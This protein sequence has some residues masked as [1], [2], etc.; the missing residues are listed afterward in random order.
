MSLISDLLSK[1]KQQEPKRDIP[2]LLKDAVLQSTTGRKARSKFTIPLVV[3]L[4]VAAGGVGALFFIDF[5]DKPAPDSRSVM[6]TMPAAR[7]HPPV[8]STSI[9]QNRP[10]G[11]L[12]VPQSVEKQTAQIA[13]KVESREIK[14]TSPVHK[15]SS[16][17]RYVK[18]I[19]PESVNDWKEVKRDKASGAGSDEHAEETE[20]IS[21]QDKDLYLYAARTYERQKDYQKALSS[22]RKVLAVD[23]RNYVVVNNISSTLIQLGSYNEAIRYAEKALQLRKDYIYS[24]INMG[25]AYSQ[26]SKYKEG[27]G[28]L[29]KA[30]SMEPSNRYVLLNL[31]LLHEKS[32]SFDK[33]RESFI[34][35]SEKGDAQGYMGLARISEKQGRT[36]EAINFYREVMSAESRDSHTWNIANDRLWQL[37]R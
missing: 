5:F 22:Y 36:A 19:T 32:G 33:A 3:A 1:V 24:L 8:A 10:V 11:A 9:Q 15:K 20:K 23:P 35:L 6:K 17:K 37:T 13:I 25:I 7:A 27:E 30:F 14:V 18:K 2:P 12:S 31:G 4:V 34:R 29:Q 26:L 16:I 28:Y 21:R